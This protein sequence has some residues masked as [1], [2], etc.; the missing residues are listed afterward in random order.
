VLFNQVLSL[1]FIANYDNS[2]S[3][4]I[5][6][7]MLALIA[8]ATYSEQ[9]RHVEFLKEES[10]ILHRAVS[11]LHEEERVM[12][13]GVA[14]EYL[15]NSRLLRDVSGHLGAVGV[16]F[17]SVSAQRTLPTPAD[18]CFDQDENEVEDL[19][20]LEAC[21]SRYSSD[22]QSESSIVD[23]QR[24]CS[25]RA[26]THNFRIPAEFQFVDEAVSGTLRKRDGLDRLLDAAKSKEF[27]VVFFTT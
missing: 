22:N 6:H 14:A 27:Q 1:G 7:P 9:A 3:A 20:P 24:I 4:K 10:R 13:Q 21:Y 16:G 18:A 26:L 19:R 2:M 23:Q 17:S 11:Q 5:F 25:E 12:S 8:S 15:A